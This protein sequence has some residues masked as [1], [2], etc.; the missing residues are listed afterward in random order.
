MSSVSVVRSTGVMVDVF[1]KKFY[2][3]KPDAIRPEAWK[4]I[5]WTMVSADICQ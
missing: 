5:Y 1:L 4:R 3:E 2:C